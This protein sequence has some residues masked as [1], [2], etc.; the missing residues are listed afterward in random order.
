MANTPRYLRGPYCSTTP[1]SPLSSLSVAA[2]RHHRFFSFGIRVSLPPP[3]TRAFPH[4][5]PFP[6]APSPFETTRVYDRNSF[7][8]SSPITQRN[9]AFLPGLSGDQMRAGTAGIS[10][11]IRIFDPFSLL[12][13]RSL[14]LPPLCILASIDRKKNAATRLFT[15]EKKI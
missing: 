1:L 2:L 7:T 9:V 14:P 5:P 11:G 4:F 8:C 13:L 3:N 6:L 15:V 10:D 12:L